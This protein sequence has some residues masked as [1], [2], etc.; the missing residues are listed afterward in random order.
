MYTSQGSNGIYYHTSSLANSDGDNSYRYAGANPNN[1]VCFGS[2]AATCPS[3]NLYRI[4]GVFGSEVKLIKNTSI[5][6]YVWNSGDINTWEVTPNIKETLNNTF[7]EKLNSLWQNKI[8]IHSWKVGGMYYSE[9][10]TAKDYYDTEIGVNSI[11]ITD[12]MMVGLMYVS[13]YGYAASSS[14][15]TEALYNYY[16]ITS[17]NWLYSGVHEWTIS[18][19]SD[20]FYNVFVIDTIGYV[21]DYNVSYFSSV[22][23]CFYLNSNVTY[24][25]GTGTQSDPFRIN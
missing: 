21:D 14:Y 19:N 5:G 6:N 8:S 23:P 7:L 20:T 10:N 13:D 24:V 2:D 12:N 9:Q 16:N 3:D 11:A 22:R 15:W 18:P 1:Y 4:I 17:N 25:S